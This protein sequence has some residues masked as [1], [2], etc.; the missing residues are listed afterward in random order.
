M[1]AAWLLVI[2]SSSASGNRDH[3]NDI[4]QSRIAAPPVGSGLLLDAAVVDCLPMAAYLCD[5]S[6]RIVCFNERARLLWG[7][8]PELHH[9]Q[10]CG[11]LKRY[12]HGRL[13][14]PNQAPSALTLGEGVCFKGEAILIERPDGTQVP[15]LFHSSPVRDSWGEVRGALVCLE[16]TRKTGSSP[17]E[18]PIPEVSHKPTFSQQLPVDSQDCAARK[19]TEA[20]IRLN[21]ERYRAATM[22]DS[23][24]FW[25]FAEHGMNEAAR[26]WWAQRT[27]QTVEEMAGFGWLNAVHPEDK[28]ALDARWRR[29]LETKEAYN[30][31][32]RVCCKDGTIRRIAARGVPLHRT[33]GTLLEWVGT[34]TDVTRE[35]EMVEAL[36]ASEAKL[37][38]IVNNAASFIFVKNLAGRYILANPSLIALQQW[39]GPEAVLGRTDYDLHPGKRQTSLWRMTSRCSRVDNP[40]SLRRVCLRFWGFER[41]W[42]KGFP[43]AMLPG[44]SWGCAALRL[45]SPSKSGWRTPS[46]GMKNAIVR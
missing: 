24:A 22:A 26:D 31:R 46:A 23:H 41:F 1:A 42:C 19:A 25:R 33:D 30:A 44:K 39:S 6:G 17:L 38:S 5:A 35:E 32:F 21:E 12:H 11:A 43:F 16:E 20:E 40:P 18:Q 10:Y 34:L 7:R 37:Q 45:K 8:K 15:T 29:S 13:I 28:A 9:E 36:R 2:P 4:C 3:M 27:H 14:S